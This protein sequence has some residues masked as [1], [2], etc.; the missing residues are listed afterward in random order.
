VGPQDSWASVAEEGAVTG[1]A[2]LTAPMVMTGG[3][4]GSGLTLIEPTKP[5]ATVAIPLMAKGTALVQWGVI[6]SPWAMD[7]TCVVVRD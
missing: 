2:A 4:L 5:E 6:A 7:L 1:G 3:T